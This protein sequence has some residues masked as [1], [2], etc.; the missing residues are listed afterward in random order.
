MTQSVEDDILTPDKASG[1]EVLESNVLPTTT[2]DSNEAPCTTPATSTG[3]GAD[4]KSEGDINVGGDIVG[5][6]KVVA[7]FLLP[8]SDKGRATLRL[9]D[10]PRLC[11]CR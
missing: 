7:L 1:L 5:R 4:L 9:E 8:A 11:A 10:N 3:G 2:P 6:D